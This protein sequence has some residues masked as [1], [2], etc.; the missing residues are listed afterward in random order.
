LGKTDKDEK[1][2]LIET[3]WARNYSF[4]LN[5]VKGDDLIAEEGEMEIEDEKGKELDETVDEC[6]GSFVA[7]W[8][9]GKITKF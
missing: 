4:W 2:M 7:R 3:V 5:V 6:T 8:L 1:A 9:R